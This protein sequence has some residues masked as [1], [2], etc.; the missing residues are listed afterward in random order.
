MST[1]SIYPFDPIHQ[2]L[3]TCIQ[4]KFKLHT[5]HTRFYSHA[6]GRVVAGGRLIGM[7]SAYSAICNLVVCYRRVIDVATLRMRTSVSSRYKQPTGFWQ[8]SYAQAMIIEFELTVDM[9]D[10]VLS[11]DG[12]DCYL[13]DSSAPK[14]P[15]VYGHV[16]ATKQ[17]RTRLLDLS[18]PSTA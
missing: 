10:W 15:H 8:D 6:L 16:V 9:V 3:I 14:C 1:N 5:N 18:I 2:L 12:V 4:A 7:T 13:L 11:R 17:F